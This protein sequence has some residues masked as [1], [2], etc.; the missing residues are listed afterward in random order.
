MKKVVQAAKQ[1]SIHE[2]IIK[3][4]KKYQTNLTEKLPIFLRT[5]AKN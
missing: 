2:F 4:P 1:A 5:K 3:L